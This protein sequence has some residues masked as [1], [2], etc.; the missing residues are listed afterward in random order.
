MSFRIAPKT[1]IIFLTYRNNAFNEEIVWCFFQKKRFIREV[2]KKK[3]QE[4][5]STW[6]VSKATLVGDEQDDTNSQQTSQYNNSFH[7]IEDLVLP[8]ESAT[9]LLHSELATWS[10]HDD[11]SSNKLLLSSA[12]ATA[13][14]TTKFI[15]GDPATWPQI[16][17]KVRC[18]LIAHGPEQDKRDNYLA[19]STTV[20]RQFNKKWFE[21]VLSNGEKVNRQWMLYSSTK[22][23][24]FCFCCILF[25]T[26]K[27]S[28][29][30]D[31]EK[32]VCD[33]KKLNPR[34]PE[35]ENSYE[36]RQC[37][38]LWKDMENKMKKGNTIDNGLQRAINAEKEKW[39]N[40]LK[41]V[42]ETILFCAKNNLAFR[43]STD[44]IGDPRSGIFL[45]TL[46]LISHYNP[47]FAEHIE[48]AKSKT[49]TV[50]YFFPKIQ[51]ELIELVGEKVKSKVISNIKEA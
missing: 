10:E 5:F 11:S 42:V 17:D 40:I 13:T 12:R 18:L 32:G 50:T 23:K 27:S 30:S 36:H 41:V 33:W 1:I 28:H 7:A 25:S 9:T 2:N 46:E 20:G 21:K 19:S 43:G 47:Q 26:T 22:E 51:N 8:E 16:G 4:L 31:L 37:Y 15:H 35:H 34:V 45:S 49:N 3:Q 6:L 38:K 39:R 14:G 44:I 24:L 48:A 29:F